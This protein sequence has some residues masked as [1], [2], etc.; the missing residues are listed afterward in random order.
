MQVVIISNI[1]ATPTQ[2]KLQ[3]FSQLSSSIA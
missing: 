1:C 2:F 3:F